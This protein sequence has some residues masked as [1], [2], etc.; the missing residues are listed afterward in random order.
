MALVSISKAA[1]LAGIARSN[2]YESY[3]NKGIL[4]LS[5]D[6][7]GRPKID[8]SELLRVFGALNLPE[9]QDRTGQQDNVIRTQQDTFKDNN[10]Q[11]VITLL[12]EQLAE[13][14][15]REK[16]YQQQI[17]ELTQS[18]KL[19]EHKSFPRLWWQFWK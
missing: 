4:S 6:E 18:I 14:R 10:Q 8:T 12:K 9:D 16:F 2:L 13:A 19:I 17:A 7:K 3:I 15:E 11:D 1:K 5:K